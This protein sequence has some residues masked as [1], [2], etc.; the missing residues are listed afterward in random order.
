MFILEYDFTLQDCDTL[1]FAG[2]ISTVHM[3]PDTMGQGHQTWSWRARVLQSLAP[4]YL[5]TPPGKFQVYLVR[6]WLAASGVFD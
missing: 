1:S 4:T 6:A 2:N 3:L 5:N